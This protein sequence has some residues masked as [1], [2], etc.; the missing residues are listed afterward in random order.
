MQLG[1][2]PWV[3]PCSAL[4]NNLARTQYNPHGFIAQKKVCMTLSPRRTQC[5]LHDLVSQRKIM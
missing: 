5:N 3:C 2:P 4:L 1:N